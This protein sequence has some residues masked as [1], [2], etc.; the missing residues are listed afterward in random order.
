[1]KKNVTGILNYKNLFTG[2]NYPVYPVVLSDLFFIDLLII[3]IMKNNT[4]MILPLSSVPDY[5][6]ILAYWSYMQW[7][8][9]REIEFNLILKSY[10]ERSETDDI[11]LSFVA[12][13]GSFPVGMVSLKEND[14]WTR[15]DLNPWLASL[16]VLPEYRRIG[17]G[18]MLVQ[19]VIKKAQQMLF[20]NLYL[21][22]GRE[23][24]IDLNSYYEKRGWKFTG[25]GE[26]ND[27][28]PT[29][30]YIYNLI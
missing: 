20:K 27:G 9:K 5:A 22:T 18:E 26:D 25:S 28:N 2:F 15:K 16:Y 24:G 4:I 6:P 21:F 11:P 3:T 30:I 1:M 7:Y 8:K 13:S 12:L 19:S 14:L 17:I 10:R 29:S 23:E